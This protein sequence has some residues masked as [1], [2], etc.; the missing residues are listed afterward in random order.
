TRGGGTDLPLSP[1][2][3]GPLPMRAPPP[4]DQSRRRAI[5]RLR[6]SASGRLSGPRRQHRWGFLDPVRGYTAQIRSLVPSPRTHVGRVGA[7]GGVD[8]RAP[9]VVAR[10]QVFQ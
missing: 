1:L 8:G 4:G 3:A 10:D 7:Y 5:A 9:A 6:L 2:G